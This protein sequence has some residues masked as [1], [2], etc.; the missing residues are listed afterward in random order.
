MKYELYNIIAVCPLVVLSS[1]NAEKWESRY[2]HDIEGHEPLETIS[3]T[4]NLHLGHPFFFFFHSGWIETLKAFL[5][6][7]IP[8][9][10]MKEYRLHHH[11]GKKKGGTAPHQ[12]R[13]DELLSKPFIYSRRGCDWINNSQLISFEVIRVFRKHNIRRRELPSFYI[14]I[15]FFRSFV[16]L[17]YLRSINQVTWK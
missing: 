14:Y 11:Q 9:N 8:G 17:Q 6:A 1:L 5:I 13:D 3:R 16:F 2:I 10:I 4:T 15:F 7:P 12:H